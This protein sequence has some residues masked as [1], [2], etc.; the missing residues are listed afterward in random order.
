MEEK[1]SLSPVS[2]LV[3]ILKYSI[4]TIINFL[5]YG[6][7][8]LL[9]AWLVDP[10]VWGQVDIFI[11]TST[12]FMNI[13]ILGL[14]QSFIRFFNEPPYPLDKHSLF[15][16]C[17]GLSTLVLVAT[18]VIS[19]V[20]FPQQV[21]A[22]FFTEKMGTIYLAMLFLNAFMAMI[23][24]YL[25]IMYR[26]EGSIKLYTI[27]SVAMQFFSKMFFLVAVFINPSFENMVLWFT[28]GMCI[29][30]FVFLWPNRSWVSFS[31]RVLFSRANRHLMPYGLALAPTAI[32]LWLNSLFS[33]VYISKTIGD[34]P[35]GVF[36]MVSLLS[37]VV[38]II[39]AGF[40]TFW[41]AFIYA[42]YKTE[43][44]KIKQVHDY[45]TFLIVEFLCLLLAFE[46]VIFFFIGP[47]YRSGMSVFPVMLLVPVFLIIAET[48]VYGISIAKKPIHD[49][50]GIGLSVV[51]NILFCMVLAP[52]FGLYGVCIALAG[53]NIA[54]FMYR[55]I[56]AQKLYCSIVSYK[57]TTLVILIMFALVFGACVFSTNFMAKLAV[58]V[59]GMVV[60]IIIYRKQLASAIALAKE[61]I[62]GF[63]AKRKQQ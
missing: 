9:V 58:S 23:A 55:T 38:A 54:M 10:A 25:N 39:Q 30:A 14:D 4:A 60:Y 53:A 45:L 26:M 16:A 42:N 61:I 43:Q 11:S 27:E 13:C 48:T 52:K 51:C 62:G 5:I 1:S 31:P 18:C 2:L 59:T 50:I 29:F 21:L 33:K 12:L 34:G 22:I 24:R 17:F 6:I 40:A 28:I 8:L 49:T 46:D 3:S 32:M 44:E 20:F 35:A 7:S 37:N 36:S 41:S 57:R 15:G 19:C 63:L 47:A 56:I